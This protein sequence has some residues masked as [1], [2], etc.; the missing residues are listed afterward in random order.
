MKSSIWDSLGRKCPRTI[1]LWWH[2]V[3]LLMEEILH[4][5]IWIISHYLQGFI[6]SGWCRISSINSMSKTWLKC[7]FA[8]A[9]ESFRNFQS[10]ATLPEAASSSSSSSLD[11]ENSQKNPFGCFVII[12]PYQTLP[13]RVNKKSLLTMRTGPLAWDSKRTP[14]PSGES[15]GVAKRPRKMDML[16]PWVEGIS[17]RKVDVSYCFMR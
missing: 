1:S 12:N 3:I 9:W 6:H 10:P 11:Q 15:L 14:C 13:I 8:C 4:Q 16:S 2:V 5:L 17:R 7:D